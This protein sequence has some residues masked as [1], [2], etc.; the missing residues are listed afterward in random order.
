MLANLR[1]MHNEKQI[2]LFLS[3]YLFAFQQTCK[4]CSNQAPH[5]ALGKPVFTQSCYLLPIPTASC[6]TLGKKPL[7]WCSLL[8]RHPCG[9]RGLGSSPN[10]N[11][12]GEHVASTPE[13]LL[14]ISHVFVSG[15]NLTFSPAKMGKK[16]LGNEARKQQVGG[17][18]RRHHH[19]LPTSVN[20]M[21]LG[22]SSYCCHGC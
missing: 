2:P 4:R 1:Q 14:W 20:L 9:G 8:P 18:T 21:F 3:L 22:S 7:S 6:S 13:T 11:A 15:I 17:D 12:L 5:S 16:A 10:L 19:H